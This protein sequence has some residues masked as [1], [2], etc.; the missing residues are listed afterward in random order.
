MINALLRELLAE[1]DAHCPGEA[2]HGERVAVY[3]VATG[4]R[5]GLAG[6]ALEKLRFAAA[7]HD[8]GKLGVPTDVL[9]IPGALTAAQIAGVRRH[10][11]LA[12]D[13]LA[14]RG[15]EVFPAIS[16]HHERWDGSGY[17]AGLIGGQ[18]LMDARIIGLAEAFDTMSY[19]AHWRVREAESA[20]IE[21]VRTRAGQEFDPD[22]VAAFLAVQPIIQPV[23]L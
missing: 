18:T 14:A 13:L 1:L 11:G 3:S 7:L 21:F 6:S 23:G 5:L 15:V 8:F 12:A 17:P 16:Q 19:G 22:V 9:S 20:A 4:Q 2:E 10:P